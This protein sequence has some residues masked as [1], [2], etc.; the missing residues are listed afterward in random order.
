MSTAQR[1]PQKVRTLRKLRR[2]T[3]DQLAERAE[4]SVDAISQIERG[5]NLPS[6]DTLDRLSAALNVPVKEFFDEDTD[7]NPRREEL[8]TSARTILLDLSDTELEIA[9]DQLR[10]FVRK[11]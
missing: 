7:T 1:F 6:F 10:A 4:R 2:L 11:K 5:V 9:V 8:L 3:Q